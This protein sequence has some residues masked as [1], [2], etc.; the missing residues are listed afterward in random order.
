M[1]TGAPEV[2]TGDC[3]DALKD[4]E[5]KVDLMVTSPPYDD[6]RVF[7]GFVEKFDWR[8]TIDAIAEALTE[9]GVCVWVV[10][11]TCDDAG[12]RRQ[13]PFRQ[14]L[15]FETAGMRLHD[16]MIWHKNEFR[17]FTAGPQRYLNAFEYMFVFSKGKPKTTNLLKDRPNKQA[18]KYVRKMSNLPERKR[19]RWHKN[20]P[21]V[22]EF[23]KRR[24]VWQFNTGRGKTA[25]DFPDAHEHP[26]IFPYAL[27]RDHIITW[28]NP[29]DLVVDP[30]CGSGTTVRAAYDLGRRAV[31]I[32]INP[33]YAELARRRMA[34]QVMN[35]AGMEE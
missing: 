24:T 11:D 16:A 30:M 6:A 26:A 1:Q 18:G 2:I 15:Y 12:A 14:S 23:G 17:F 34:Q 10:N 19:G 8:K 21:A 29:G 9:G 27:A 33:E 7:G 20:E 35:M 22:Q 28:S 32:E 25:P 4:Y 13:T 5:G 3:V 31:G